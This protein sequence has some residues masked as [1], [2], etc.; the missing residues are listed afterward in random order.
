MALLN[1]P[2]NYFAVLIS[3]VVYFLIGSIWF[4][5]LFGKL[6]Q[7]E[8]KFSKEDVEK[9]KKKNMTTAYIINFIATVVS[10]YVL[11]VFAGLLGV[12]SI[13]SGAYLG[14]LVWVGFFAATAIGTILWEG[15]SL[16]LYLINMGYH[17]V[18]LVIAGAILAVM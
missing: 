1:V 11:A 3:A 15:K 7:K 16:E 18:S 6:W 12:N 17:L 14:F 5:V 2:I 4:S 8:M 9:A 13:G 10:V